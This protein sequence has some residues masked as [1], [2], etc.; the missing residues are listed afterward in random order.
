[1]DNFTLTILHTQNL[2]G[3]LDILPPLATVLLRLRREAVGRVLMLDAGA[4]CA[5]SSPDCVATQG[6]AALI[7]LDAIGYDA[8]N[9]SG[10]LDGAGRAKLRDNMMD[11]ALA[12]PMHPYVADGVAFA[13]VPPP[14]HP[15]RLHIP[16]A[17]QGDA[18]TVQPV[19]AMGFVYAVTLAAVAGA[20]IGETRLDVTLTGTT[21]THHAIH[22]VSHATPPDPSISGA[23]EFVRDEVRYYGRKRG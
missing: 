4:A 20:Q 9:V 21:I 22:T 7:V 13:D 19:E 14:A 17:T 5:D 3:R 11:I 23:V 12:D 8:A 2:L 1:M 15:H 6:R 18:P 10:Y 16:F